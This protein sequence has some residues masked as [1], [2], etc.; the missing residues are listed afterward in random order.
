VSKFAQKLFTGF[1]GAEVV[2]NNA[3]LFHQRSARL[4]SFLDRT[5]AV[6][7]PEKPAVS[8]TGI[9]PG[10]RGK[11]GGCWC[12]P[13]LLRA[14]GRQ[15]HITSSS[16]PE[17]CPVS[18]HEPGA[19]RRAAIRNRTRAESG[20]QEVSTCGPTQLPQRVLVATAQTRTHSRFPAGPPRQKAPLARTS[21]ARNGSTSAGSERTWQSPSTSSNRSGVKNHVTPLQKRKQ[22][23]R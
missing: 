6:R 14:S 7:R 22:P 20:T 16:D 2:K 18:S 9:I 5:V 15:A 11:A 10:D 13:P 17:S 21:R 12:H 19:E 1:A 4:P 23:E 3:F 8:T